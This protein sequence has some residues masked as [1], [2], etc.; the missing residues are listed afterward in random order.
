[1]LFP[2]QLMEKS[3]W[4]HLQKNNRYIVLKKYFN[5]T[6]RNKVITVN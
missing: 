4:I 5:I 2:K 1:M 3:H 6:T